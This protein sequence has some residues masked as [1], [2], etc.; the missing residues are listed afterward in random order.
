MDYDGVDG[1]LDKQLVGKCNLEEVRQ[2]AK[3]AHKCLHKSPRK[4]PSIGEVSLGI[5]R[6]KQK[7]LM[8]EDSMS[9]ASSNF[10]RSVSQIE[11]QQV[12]LTKI[13]TINHREM[14]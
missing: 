13:T 14:G 2:L 10:S 7:R 9:F 8:K 4:R 11:E 6:I 3:I 12:E 5:L 1:I